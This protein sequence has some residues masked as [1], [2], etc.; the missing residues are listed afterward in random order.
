MPQLAANVTT[1][2]YSPSAQCTTTHVSSSRQ[3][4]PLLA[5]AH[6]QPLQ[7]T[8]RRHSTAQHSDSHLAVNTDQITPLLVVKPHPSTSTQISASC[9]DVP[10][11]ISPSDRSTSSRAVI[12]RQAQHTTRRQNTALRSSSSK[13]L[14]ALH[15][16]PSCHI[17][18]QLAFGSSHP[19]GDTIHLTS[20]RQHNSPQDTT[21]RQARPLPYTSVHAVSTPRCIARRHCHQH[22]G[23][24]AELPG[25]PI[26]PLQ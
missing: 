2:R 10:C 15:V 9:Q 6:I 26:A 21:R 19:A 1:T 13:Q 23:H 16:S 11:H 18:S 22:V 25:S 12:A 4:T 24:P 14:R 3:P 17:A 5:A 7:N 8:T 20:C